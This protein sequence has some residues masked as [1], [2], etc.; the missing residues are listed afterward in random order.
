VDTVHWRRQAGQIPPVSKVF[1]SCPQEQDQRS[2]FRGDQ[3]HCG[4][5][6][7]G[8]DGPRL[9]S[10]SSLGLSTVVDLAEAFNGR[11]D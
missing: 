8:P 10:C 5:R 3:P 7:R 4:H 1:H 11:A 6:M 2:S 9:P